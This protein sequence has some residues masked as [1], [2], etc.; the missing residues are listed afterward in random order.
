MSL[1]PELRQRILDE[2]RFRV[3]A[4]ERAREEIRLR[5]QSVS[6]VLRVFLMVA[7][8]S[9]AYV[10]SHAYLNR[11]QSVPE[12]RAAAPAPAESLLTPAVLD[13]VARALAPK[14]GAEVCV[15]SVG[16]RSHP[17]IKA[18]IEL[19]LDAPRYTARR[20]AMEK[21][22]DVGAALREHGLAVPAY[23]EIFSPNRWYGMAVYDRDT[24]RIAWDPCPGRCDREGTKYVKR[25][26]VAAEP[27]RSP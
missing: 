21:A 13:D 4:R 12:T 26:P 22:R 27:A 23:V 11:G 16:G 20:I 15:R 8:F 1:S 7:L 6:L 9:A 5:Q 10:V 25:C 3:E 18:T 17:Q 19:S 2:E 14:A 24:L